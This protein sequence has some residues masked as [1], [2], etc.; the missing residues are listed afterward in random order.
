MSSLRILVT[1]AATGADQTAEHV[2]YSL[3]W[4][5]EPHLADWD[6]HG[7]AAGP[8][9]NREMVAAGA[10]VCVAF[11]GGRGTQHCRDTAA[12]AG[13]PVIDVPGGTDG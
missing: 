4:R 13:I 3:G 2:A 1:G 5:T 11:P 9:R 10:D 8:I 7:N 6:S 12:A